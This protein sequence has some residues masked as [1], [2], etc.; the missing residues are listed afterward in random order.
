MKLSTTILKLEDEQR[1]AYGWGLVNIE[2][3]KPVV[4]SQGDIVST[5]VLQKAVHEFIAESREG[6]VMHDVDEDDPR[7]GKVVAK[8]VD[9]VVMTPELQKALGIDLK[10]VGWLVGMK[11]DDDQTWQELKDGKL[12]MF[13][14]EGEGQR[15]PVEA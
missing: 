9:S 14:I 11:V 3:G 10:K 7:Y 2:D 5:A 12:A 4:D 13:S 1:I 6:N 8:M 15:I